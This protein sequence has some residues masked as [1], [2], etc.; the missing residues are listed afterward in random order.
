M[1]RQMATITVDE[2]FFEQHPIHLRDTFGKVIAY[3]ATNECAAFS[4]VL[5]SEPEFPTGYTVRDRR[6]GAT[7]T[8][9]ECVDL[10]IES[11]RPEDELEP[12]SLFVLRERL[13]RAS[14]S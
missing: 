5:R 1:G 12:V 9:A 13:L 7:L 3:F 10:Y 14:Q 4:A 6:D 11:V 2:R 8:F